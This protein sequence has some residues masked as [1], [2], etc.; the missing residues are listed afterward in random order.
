MSKK[1]EKENQIDSS[2]KK[3]ETSS[4]IKDCY[5]DLIEYADCIY[6]E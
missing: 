3:D 6:N 4:F 5:I 2:S 1:E